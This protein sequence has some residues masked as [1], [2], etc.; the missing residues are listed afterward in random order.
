MQSDGKDK[1]SC[2]VIGSQTMSG[3]TRATYTVYNSSVQLQ[4]KHRGAL[5]QWNTNSAS[6]RLTVLP[7]YMF[8]FKWA[9]RYVCV[10]V[11]LCVAWQLCC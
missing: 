10:S 5:T 9:F 2:N 8:I 3:D 6:A 4:N 1:E 7:R 11:H